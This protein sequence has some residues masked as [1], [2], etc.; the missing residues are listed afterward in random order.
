MSPRASALRL[1]EETPVQTSARWIVALVVLAA[2]GGVTWGVTSYK[3]ANNASDIE[4]LK[5]E[6]RTSR[7]LLVRVDE[8]VKRLVREADRRGAKTP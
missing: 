2:T 1:T 4:A 7:E 3:V 8:N 6:A 5:T